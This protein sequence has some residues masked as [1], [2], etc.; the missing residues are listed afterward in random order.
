[1]RSSMNTL[2]WLH[3]IHLKSSILLT[4]MDAALKGVCSV[5]VFGACNHNPISLISYWTLRT[6]LLFR[7]LQ[8]LNTCSSR[9]PAPAWL[10]LMRPDTRPDATLERYSEGRKNHGS[11]S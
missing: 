7:T 3:E 5:H 8:Q 9:F 11:C 4:E 2:L 6:S 1:M 10:P